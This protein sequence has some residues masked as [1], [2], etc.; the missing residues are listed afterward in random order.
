MQKLNQPIKLELPNYSLSV[1]DIAGR[2]ARFTRAHYRILGRLF[3]VPIALYCIGWQML[4]WV[5]EYTK[6]MQM[7][8]IVVVLCFFV[9][10][11]MFYWMKVAAVAIWLMLAGKEDDLEKAQKKANRLI[12]LLVFLPNLIL[13]LIMTSWMTVIIVWLDEVSANTAGSD[14]TYQAVV[15]VISYFALLLFSLLPFRFLQ[16]VN[17]FFGFH[18]LVSNQ[19]LKAGFQQTLQLFA[20][21]GW[22]IFWA[23]NFFVVVENLIEVPN[24][25]GLIVESSSLSASHANKPL[26]AFLAFL[27]RLTL[28]VFTG[29]ITCSISAVLIPIFDNELRVRIEAKDITDSLSRLRESSA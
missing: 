7:R 12:T 4:Y 9:I 10:L 11:A 20:R 5:M 1:A 22:L 21:K 28:E 3:V 2:A 6:S 25:I 23:F 19:T 18:L 16:L 17:L 8:A 14:R 27:P 24:W 26:T 15:I 29:V 13:E